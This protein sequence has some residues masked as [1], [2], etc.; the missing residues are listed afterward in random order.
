MENL[1]CTI[2]GGKPMN[3]RL[4]LLLRLLN[5]IVLGLI[6]Q[7]FGMDW[8]VIVG[9]VLVVADLDSIAEELHKWLS[10]KC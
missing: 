8:V 10:K 3:A 2:T 9:F 5:L 1:Y 6:R 4:K 7:F